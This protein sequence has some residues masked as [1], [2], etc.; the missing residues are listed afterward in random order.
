MTIRFEAASLCLLHQLMHGHAEEMRLVEIPARRGEPPVPAL[1]RARQETQ[2]GQSAMRFDGK[3]RIGELTDQDAA[4]R[5]HPRNL[6][7]GCLTKGGRN[8]LVDVRERDAIEMIRGKADL[9]TETGAQ[10]RARR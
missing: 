10:A 2:E 8:M 6:G 7:Q 4:G 9:V 1:G 5:Q 3:M